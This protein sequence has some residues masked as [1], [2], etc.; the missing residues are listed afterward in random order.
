MCAW[1]EDAYSYYLSATYYSYHLYQLSASY[2]VLWFSQDTQWICRGQLHE[3][4]LDYGL[5]L[6]NTSVNTPPHP[7]TVIIL[8]TAMH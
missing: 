2:K 3:Y 8:N 4:R 1:C 5:N 7:L 6:S